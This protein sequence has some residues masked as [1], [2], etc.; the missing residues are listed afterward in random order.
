MEP[1][2]SENRVVAPAAAEQDRPP[3]QL[4][5]AVTVLVPCSLCWRAGEPAQLPTESTAFASEPTAVLLQQGTVVHA[6]V[7]VAPAFD[8]GFCCGAAM[9]GLGGWDCFQC[10]CLNQSELLGFAQPIRLLS[11]A[12]CFM[13]LEICCEHD[14]KTRR[15]ATSAPAAAAETTA[16]SPA[17]KTEIPALLPCEELSP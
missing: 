11:I 12:M 17:A 8:Y 14:W 16:A 6:V 3:V 15:L 4:T 2:G 5:C 10:G 9:M 7:L 13:S 1:L